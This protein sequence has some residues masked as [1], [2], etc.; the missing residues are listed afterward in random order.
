MAGAGFMGWAS[1]G[2]NNCW[3]IE[4]S[5]TT[6]KGLGWLQGTDPSHPTK[7]NGNW[8]QRGQGQVT[9]LGQAGFLGKGVRHGG[10]GLL[11]GH[12]VAWDHPAGHNVLFL[13]GPVNGGRLLPNN[14]SCLQQMSPPGGCWESGVTVIN[15]ALG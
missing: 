2:N 8:A 1:Q 7:L 6:T 5:V 14:G 15:W 12:K 13:S 3:P 4:G 9:G 10:L 11:L